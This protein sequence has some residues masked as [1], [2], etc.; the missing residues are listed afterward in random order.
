MIF[1]GNFKGTVAHKRDNVPVR[2]NDEPLDSDEETV[3]FYYPKE[4]EVL[5]GTIFPRVRV[6]MTEEAG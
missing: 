1:E 2:K 6:F 4:Q 3:E 5:L